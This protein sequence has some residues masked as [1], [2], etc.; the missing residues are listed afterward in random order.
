MYS[1]ELCAFGSDRLVRKNI[2]SLLA[3][4]VGLSYAWLGTFTSLNSYFFN[5]R[6]M[7]IPSWFRLGATI[8]LGLYLLGVYTTAL[9]FQ[10]IS[11]KRSAIEP[12]FLVLGCIIGLLVGSLPFF[13]NFLIPIPY[14]F[15]SPYIILLISLLLSFL[16]IRIACRFERN[17][18]NS[19]RRVL[20]LRALIP[21][22]IALTLIWLHNNS[23]PSVNAPAEIRQEWAYIQ[24]GD[25]KEVVNSIKT[26]QPIL[27]R[28]GSVK[29]VAPTQGR[30]YIIS[31]PGSS[32]HQGELTLEV[33]GDKG[34]GVANFNFHI[35]TSVSQV[36][37]TNRGKT[38]TIVCRN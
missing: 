13:L 6:A 35:V 17:K 30:N 1:E 2:V 20:L 8:A 36:R 18:S 15:Y 4:L 23:F 33:I 34:V 5:Y 24:F 11:T 27:E 32:G 14:L 29:V 22:A 12:S 9:A 26:C 25:Y 7:T 3:V 21:C 38:E 16:G 19:T 37:F 28:V 10:Q 31:D